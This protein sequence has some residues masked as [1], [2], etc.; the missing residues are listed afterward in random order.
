M[1]EVG[2]WKGYEQSYEQ[3]TDDELCRSREVRVLTRPGLDTAG[4]ESQD[5]QPTHAVAVC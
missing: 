3:K 1:A 2:T 4:I 5:P